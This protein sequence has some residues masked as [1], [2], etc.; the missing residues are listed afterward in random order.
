[1]EGAAIFKMEDNSILVECSEIIDESFNLSTEE[2]CAMNRDEFSSIAIQAQKKM[3]NLNVQR[4]FLESESS[5][6]QKIIRYDDISYQSICYLRA[7]RPEKL[8]ATSE[9]PDFH[10]ET[11]YSDSPETTRH[12][13]NI[14]IPIK[15]VNN[16]NTLKYIPGSQ[17]IPDDQIHSKHENT[18][19]RVK[20][21]SDAHK[22]G[23]FWAPK[24]IVGGVD[25]DKAKPAKFSNSMGEYL[26]FSSM[27]IHGGAFNKTDKIR[28]VVGFGLIATDKITEN[29]DYY[30]SGKK[31]F[32][33]F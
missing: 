29:K 17:N 7:V 5:K 24:E 8:S 31:Y 2:Y 23:F 9:A 18:L 10:R 11:F 28:F 16:A 15:N 12:M 32:L 6:I 13:L 14:W 4:R 27:T 33:K 22:L 1:M 3:N 20:K 26:A 19:P 25:L 30:A 21:F